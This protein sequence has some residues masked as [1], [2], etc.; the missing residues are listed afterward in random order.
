VL[1][2]GALLVWSE[3]DMTKVP[4]EEFESAWAKAQARENL[5]MTLAIPVVGL[6]LVLGSLGLA[7]RLTGGITPAEELHWSWSGL[8]RRLPARV[9]WG[10]AWG[11]VLGLPFGLVLG[12]IFLLLTR[13]PTWT[14]LGASRSQGLP[15]CRPRR[16]PWE[17]SSG[18]SS[19]WSSG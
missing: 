4:F 1:A 18:W 2:A 5:V 6:A 10:S 12:L 13:G 11:L 3:P 8:G 7:G 16:W 15:W 17:C 19:G 9:M 14:R